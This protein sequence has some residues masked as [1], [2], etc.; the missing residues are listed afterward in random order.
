VPSRQTIREQLSR[1]LH[2]RDITGTA[3][4]GTTSTLVVNNDSRYIAA[5]GLSDDFW[6]G[7]WILPTS[8]NEDGNVRIITS[9]TATSGTF[10][11]SPAWGTGP[12]SSDTF[13]LWS[14]LYPDDATIAIDLALRRM[15]H[16]V[17]VPIT[18][19]T[20]G[21]METSGTSSWT[22]SNATVTKDTDAADV[23]Y[24]F[25][26]S[27]SLSVV[28]TSAGGYAQSD[29]IS[30]ESG[31]GYFVWANL[32]AGGAF[33]ARLHIQDVTNGAQIGSNQD[34]THNDFGT[35]KLGFTAPSDCDNVAVRIIG[36]ENS[37]TIHANN[38]QM[39]RNSAYWYTLPSFIQNPRA[40]VLEV[41]SFTGNRPSEWVPRPWPQSELAWDQTAANI[42]SIFINPV[43]AGGGQP[44]LHAVRPFL[45]ETG[46]L[47]TDAT[48]T[49]AN[50][51]W[52]VQ[53]AMVECYGLLVEQSPASETHMWDQRRREAVERYVR[54]N[55]RWQRPKTSR[56]LRVKWGV[57]I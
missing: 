47:S 22:A 56:R 16:N 35:V 18:L 2:G 8:G 1:R 43:G 11:I 30:V 49:T 54:M 3:T 37:A 26:G 42:G 31:A 45:G 53:A 21:D 6:D 41:V 20:D 14:R 48:T 46:T 10:N 52:V 24:V 29:N 19:V 34:W 32:R 50:L 38:V 33:T 9:F 13:E 15:F 44:F 23:G 25:H 55:N 51:D 40:D 17:L 36:A 4:G 28:T 27:Q 5:T 57:G 12:A 7:W 39:I